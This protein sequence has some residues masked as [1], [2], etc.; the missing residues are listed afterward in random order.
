MSHI[1]NKNILH[2]G[3]NYPKGSKIKSSDEGF[4]EIVKG[5]HADPIDPEAVVEAPAEVEVEVEGSAAK[6]KKKQK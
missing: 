4:K 2:N 1:L 6:N 3:K 5:G